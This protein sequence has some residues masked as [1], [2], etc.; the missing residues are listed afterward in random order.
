M[1][2]TCWSPFNISVPYITDFHKAYLDSKTLAEKETLRLG[3]KNESQLEV[4]SLVCGLIGGDALLPF[5]PATL[6][7]FVSQLTNNEIHYNSL[8]YL[9]ALL[10]KVPIVH[11][12]DVCEA[13]IFC[14][15]SP[16]LR[17]RFLCATS[18]V[19]RA[20]IA[21]YHQQNYPQFHVKEE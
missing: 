2:E 20:G 4:V 16:S 9:E 15:E 21:S 17:G 5:T 7:V 11:I 19:S 14:M 8:K 12:D 3:N 18:Y 1:D 6:A 13:H 10:G